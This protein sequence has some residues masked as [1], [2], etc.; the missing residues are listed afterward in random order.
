MF[1]REGPQIRLPVDLE[2][3][4]RDQTVAERYEPSTGD[5]SY[6]DNTFPVAWV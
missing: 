1:A 4:G 2:A 6:Q 5:V 3:T